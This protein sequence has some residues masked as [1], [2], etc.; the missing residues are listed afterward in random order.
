VRLLPTVGCMPRCEYKNNKLLTIKQFNKM[1][2]TKEVSEKKQ[3][4]IRIVSQ[5]SKKVCFCGT[6][7]TVTCGDNHAYR[8]CE[9]GH[10]K[11]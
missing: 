6:K 4:D 10:E 5:R 8:I 2:N 11:H 9:N 7:Q 1:E 3:C